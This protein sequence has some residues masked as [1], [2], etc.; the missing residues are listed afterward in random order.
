[1]QA[2]ALSCLCLLGS[3]AALLVPGVEQVWEGTMGVEQ[4]PLTDRQLRVDR[5]RLIMAWVLGQSPDLGWTRVSLAHPERQRQHTVYDVWFLY[6]LAL[7]T[8]RG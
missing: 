3:G 5:W 6:K 7:P 4:S 1:M 2:L 8:K